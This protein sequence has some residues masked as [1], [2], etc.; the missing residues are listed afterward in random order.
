[1]SAWGAIYNNTSSALRTHAGMLARLQ[2][3]AASGSRVIRPSDDPSDANR[4]L[5]L[6]AQTL[7]LEN[8]SKNLRTVVLA[9]EQS[10]DVVQEISSG[11][12]RIRQLLTQASSGTYGQTDLCIIA[13]EIDCMLEQIVASI[14]TKTLGRYLFGGS[15]MSATPYAVEHTG[16]RIATVQYQGSPEDLP[17]PVA[18]GVNDSGTMVADHVFRS[19]EP[20]WPVFLGNTGAKA[21]KGVST[22]SDEVSLTVSHDT[23]AYD[24]GGAGSGIIAGDSSPAGD[25]ILGG[26]TLTINA[27]AETIKLD[28][29]TPIAFNVETDLQV[30]NAVGDIVYVNVSNWNGS[31]D[32]TIALAASGNVSIDGGASTTPVTFTDNQAVTHS[33]AGRVLYVDT[34]EIVRTGVDTVRVTAGTYDVFGTLINIRDTLLGEDG[35]SDSQRT[36]RLSELADSLE[37][38]AEGVTRKLTTVGGRLQAMDALH[39]SLETL[40][41][42]AGQEASMLQDADV[43]Q[44]AIDLAR[45]QTLYEM[46]LM[47]ASKLLS[48]SLLDFI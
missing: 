15:D 37:G 27:V 1:M 41:A 20:W 2:E 34:S 17:V 32:G 16:G 36:E 11:L 23:T 9:M 38:A 42:R 24:D 26:H 18:P 31:F 48:L 22:I 30:Q 47:T 5:H 21:G 3:Q 28:D 25:S 8:Y 33:T 10:H 39:N 43:I 45:T 40:K 35:L 13:E 46:T 44:L 7:T 14:N 29:G 12:T 4:I 6:R 19:R